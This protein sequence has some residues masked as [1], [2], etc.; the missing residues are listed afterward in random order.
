[1][2]AAV[3]ANRR[4]ELAAHAEEL[5]IDWRARLEGLPPDDDVRR[6]H[7]LASLLRF[8]TERVFDADTKLVQLVREANRLELQREYAEAAMADFEVAVHVPLLILR[9]SDYQLL[10]SSGTDTFVEDPLRRTFFRR[11]GDLQMQ[12]Y[13]TVA[14]KTVYTAENLAASVQVNGT[15]IGKVAPRPWGGEFMVRNEHVFFPFDQGLLLDPDPINNPNFRNEFAIVNA[16]AGPPLRD[17][18]V[19]V[20]HILF[21][22]RWGGAH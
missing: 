16:P 5:G 6:V 10:E 4:D 17:R 20:R 15:E 9:H 11:K 19:F 8:D 1:M 7:A 18:M 22:Y 14:V 21:H 2:D 3:L 13:F 12:P